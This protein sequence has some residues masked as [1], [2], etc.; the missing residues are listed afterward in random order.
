MS[1]VKETETIII[2]FGFSCVPLLRELDRTGEKYLILSDPAPSSVWSALKRAGRLNFDLVSSYYTSFYS[3]DLVK[4]FRKDMYPL[5][6]D[7]Y[8][9]H[10]SYYEKYKDQIIRTHVTR[11]ENHKGFSIVHTDDGSYKCTNVVISTAF[12]RKIHDSL[13][14][15][16]YSVKDKTI[17]FDTVGDS[18][19]LM[20]S[21][22]LSGNN[23]IVCVTN[24]F[25]AFDK[26]FYYKGK[27]ATLD[28]F[29]FHNLAP[30]GKFYRAF[31]GG[32]PYLFDQFFTNIGGKLKW[33]LRAARLL[34]PE[35]F[36]FKYPELIHRDEADMTRYNKG[37]AF[38]NGF[39]AIKYWPIDTYTE[40]F[41]KD[42]ENAIRQGYLL[43]DLP[44]WIEEGMVK[45]CKK[46]ETRID[47]ERKTL[48]YKDQVISYDYFVQGGPETPRLPQI[49]IM[50]DGSGTPPEEYKYRVRKNYLG[51][52]P[53]NLSNVFLLGL[54]R[55]FTGGLANM[56]EMQCLFIHKMIANKSFKESVTATLP[57]RIREYEEKYYITAKDKPTDH[58]VYY[59]TYTE[60]VAKAIGINITAKDCRSFGDVR[61]WLLFPNNAF[62]YRQFGEYA[63]EKCS[64][65]VRYIEKSHDNWTA[66]VLSTTTIGIYNLI[67]ILFIAKL[68]TGGYVGLVGVGV[69]ALLYYFL[70]A[71]NLIILG[72]LA[73]SPVFISAFNYFRFALVIIFLIATIWGPPA[74]VLPI[75]GVEILMTVIARRY[76]KDISRHFFND[77]ANKR[78]YRGF[79]KEYMETYRKVVHGNDPAELIARSASRAP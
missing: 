71:R 41:G 77:M 1:S 61:R 40:M 72:L 53:E 50:N 49:L 18:S 13:C 12:T 10:L 6:G 28:Q 58:L 8:A 74:I 79:I 38:P 68:F 33:K 47:H 19:N 30:L 29:E 67:A 48:S 21:K 46:S 73:A 65:F 11:I 4:D 14:S 24:G 59:G 20:I 2:G 15:F 42:L 26:L 3:F 44:L 36:W 64:E 31:I 7:F 60:E 62:K 56:T 78:Q 69:L 70:V 63:V 45:I 57:R 5:A 9:M 55:P 17:V 39:I 54:I 66:F 76:R 32:S 25:L 75:F 22:L 37:A 35:I 16:D 34:T 51:V 43:N 27:T 52:M 23:K